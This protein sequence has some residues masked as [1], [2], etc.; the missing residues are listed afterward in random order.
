VTIQENPAL[1]VSHL[2]TTALGNR[3]PLWWGILLAI[4]IETTGFA[5]V[6]SVY[7]Y[8]RMQEATWPPWRWSAPDL[9]A[10]S[11][12][13][14]VILA[15]AI[16]MYLTDRAAKAHDLKRVRSLLVI[17]F[18]TTLL[19]GAVRIWEFVGLQVK[20]DSNAY[21]SIVWAM[22]TLHTVHI[23]TSVGETAILAAYL[24]VRPLDE[25]HFWTWRSRLFIGISSSVL[26][27]RPS[28]CSIWDRIS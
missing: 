26:G 17:F 25:K 14:L 1:D 16:P 15:T 24:F 28:S 22:L 21:G 27:Y 18:A 6:W 20:W 9:L 4:A 8:L 11:V 19:A 7:L 23:V 5:I 3:A 10:G 2:P 12:S 13:T